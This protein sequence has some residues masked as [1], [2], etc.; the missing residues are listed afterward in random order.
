MALVNC[1][2]LIARRLT[3]ERSGAPMPRVAIIDWDFEAPGV[4][5][6]L[7]PYLTDESR[8][9]SDEAPGCLELFA[10]LAKVPGDFSIDD[11]SSNRQ[12]VAEL[13]QAREWNSYLLETSISGLSFMKAGRFD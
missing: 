7:H 9:K 10:E 4:H 1:A 11:A 8:L 5:R 12:R 6:Y 2:C 3:K 13:L